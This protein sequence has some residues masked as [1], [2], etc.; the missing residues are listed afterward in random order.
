MSRKMTAL[1]FAAVVV[2]CAATSVFAD[3]KLKTRTTVA[4]QGTE[5]TTYIKGQRQRSSQNFGGFEMVM[6]T[7]CDLKRTVQIND[8]AKT[9]LITPLDQ[10]TPAREPAAKESSRE[11]QPTRTRKGGVVTY[12]TTIN[13]TGERKKM[14]GYNARHIT[15]QMS[16]ESSPDA[17][18]QT[19]MRME[20]DGWYIDFEFSFDCNIDHPPVQAM[21]GRG[22]KPDCQDEVRLKRVGSAKLGYPVLVTTT[23]YGEGG[24]TT[25]MT[26]EVL[27]LSS[28]TLD[29]ALFEIPEGYTEAKDFQ[30]LMGIPSMESIR[31]GQIPPQAQ[32]AMTAHAGAKQPGTLRVGVVNINN[33][34][35]RT[36]QLGSVRGRLI[37][38]IIGSNIDAVP[39]DSTSPSDIEAEAKQKSCDF[40]LYTDVGDLKKSGKVGGLLGRATGVGSL[41]EKY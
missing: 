41:N 32:E 29:A 10:S 31:R 27:E 8:N 13:D 6:L 26:T 37:S 23:I 25:T 5:G 39:I 7:Q 3:L 36:A 24:Q 34:T 11:S 2:C 35:D 22:P 4:G 9:Y 18:N 17:C 16:A 19:K 28:A 33:K 20:T 40:I 1:I 30:Q 15:T 12:T 21:P 14:F 38:S